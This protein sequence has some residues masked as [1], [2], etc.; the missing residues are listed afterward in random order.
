VFTPDADFVDTA[1]QWV[2]RRESIAS[3]IID[4]ELPR[5]GNRTRTSGIVKLTP[6]YS[7]LA[8]AFVRW[9]LQGSHPSSVPTQ[10]MGLRVLESAGVSWAIVVAA[11]TLVRAS[12]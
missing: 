8:V 11:D 1:A 2:R 4:V 9:N 6:V 7:D 12:A 3:H 10:G 5:L